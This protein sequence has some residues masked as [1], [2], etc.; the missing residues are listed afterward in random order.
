[1]PSLSS[2]DNIEHHASAIFYFHEIPDPDGIP[3]MEVVLCDSS[4]KTFYPRYVQALNK[5]G[6][7]RRAT[8]VDDALEQTVVLAI[9]MFPKYAI[10]SWGNLN[11]KHN[12]STL[13]EGEIREYLKQL[14]E[15]LPDVLKRFVNFAMTPSN[16][17]TNALTPEEVT[18]VGEGSGS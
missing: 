4:N 3:Y 1:M 6:Q 14:H 10:Q 15:H 2:F 17:R 5:K 16:F 8:S 9:E 7:A 18:E 12:P 11:G 13:N